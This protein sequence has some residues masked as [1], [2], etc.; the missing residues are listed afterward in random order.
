MLLGKRAL[1]LAI[2]LGGLVAVGTGLAGM[3]RGPAMVD[4][5]ALPA[6]SLDSHYRYL[7]GLLL[8]IGLGYWSAIPDILRKGRRFRL[9]TAIVAT[10]GLGRLISFVTAGVPDGAMLLG[11]GMELGV[12][13]LLALWQYRLSR[14]P[15]R[16]GP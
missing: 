14:Q 1:Q 6:L 12:A 2:A 7:S 10:G 4:A 8:G 16:G 13:P 15:P 9:L 3:V 5:V 11:L